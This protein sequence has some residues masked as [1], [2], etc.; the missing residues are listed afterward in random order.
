ME[1]I[2]QTSCEVPGLPP[3]ALRHGLRDRLRA[4]GIHLLISV[5]V[6]LL[7]LG[8][9]FLCWYPAPL[10]R[11]SGVGQILVLLL[12]VDVILGP[13]L[14]LVVY[15]RRKRSLRKDLMVIAAL[16]LAALGYGLHTV[17]AGRP[18]YLVFVMDRFEVVSRADLTPEDLDAAADNPAAAIRLLGPKPVVAEFFDDPS[19][20]REAMLESVQGG[21]DLQHYPTQYRPI[22]QA[23]PQIISK[24]QRLAELR[25]LNPSDAA[26]IDQAVQGTGRDESALRYL[27]IKGPVG[28]A[29]VL[30]EAGS[31]HLVGLVDLR[32]WN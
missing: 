30:V 5:C 20:R 9:V 28:D 1:S 23:Y 3:A 25:K 16:Q 15:D 10:D 13:L 4:A 6:A 12:V 8:L 17:E 2:N 11:I 29:A 22:D 32:P 26:R 27:P 31:G 24:G 21:R 7:V 18:H 14:T 19:R